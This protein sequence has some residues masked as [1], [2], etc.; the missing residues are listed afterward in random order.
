MTAMRAT[1]CLILLALAIAPL[2]EPKTR[3][4]S[5]TTTTAPPLTPSI[6]SRRQKPRA[7]HGQSLVDRRMLATRITATQ[8]TVVLPRLRRHPPRT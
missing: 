7:L 1:L 2:L 8:A 3:R 6:T 5:T 4:R